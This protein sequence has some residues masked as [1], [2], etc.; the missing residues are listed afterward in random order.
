MAYET[1]TFRLRQSRWKLYTQMKNWLNS[2]FL[3]KGYML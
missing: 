3:L 2:P 1:F